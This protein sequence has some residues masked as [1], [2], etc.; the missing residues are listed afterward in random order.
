MCAQVSEEPSKKKAKQTT[1]CECVCVRVLHMTN[2]ANIY[3]KT[4][5]LKEQAKNLI[6]NNPQIV[7]F[8]PRK[9]LCD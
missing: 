1:E 3:P 7:N 5:E 8:K 6:A 4:N 9:R 2:G